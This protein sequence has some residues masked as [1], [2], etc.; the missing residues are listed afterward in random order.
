ML[1]LEHA[2][3]HKDDLSQFWT[4]ATYAHFDKGMNDL[5][6]DKIVPNVQMLQRSE[7]G[8]SL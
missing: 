1:P 2:T 8:K 5:S 3:G 4:F 7:F 6:I